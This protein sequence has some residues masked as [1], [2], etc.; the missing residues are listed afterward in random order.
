MKTGINQARFSCGFHFKNNLRAGY[1]TA[2]GFKGVLIIGCIIETEIAVCNAVIDRLATVN[3][4]RVA[5]V[6]GQDS[7]IN[8][9]NALKAGARQLDLGLSASTIIK[10]GEF[11]LRFGLYLC[12]CWSL[13][14]DQT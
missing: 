11:E 10:D 3:E 12:P 14:Y 6:L 8:L 2:N 7:G 13:Q 4:A 1:L 9:F 5:A